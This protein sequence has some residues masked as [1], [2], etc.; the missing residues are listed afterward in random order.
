MAQQV[1]EIGEMLNTPHRAL[2]GANPVPLSAHL[3]FHVTSPGLPFI[4]VS[5]TF[6][7]CRRPFY[8]SFV[9]HS[10]IAS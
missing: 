1:L 2:S 10:S 3:S 6:H 9:L 5:K 8:L 7:C 4:T